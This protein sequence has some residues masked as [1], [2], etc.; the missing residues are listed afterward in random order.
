MVKV[1]DA[2]SA[3][4]A[5][6]V[7]TPPDFADATARRDQIAG[8]GAARYE[9]DELEAL[10]GGALILVVAAPRATPSYRRKPV[11]SGKR[12]YFVRRGS[13]SP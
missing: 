12:V 11:N 7:P 1:D 4:L 10:V 6:A 9:I 8:L 5:A 2:D 3:S 13:D